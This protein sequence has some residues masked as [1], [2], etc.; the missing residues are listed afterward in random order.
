MFCR[1]TDGICGGPA[2]VHHVSCLEASFAFF[3]PS[4]LSGF[5]IIALRKPPVSASRNIKFKVIKRDFVT[6]GNA[7]RLFN[8]QE[9]PSLISSGILGASS[10]LR[11]LCLHLL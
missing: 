8:T 1:D 11:L 6:V 9:Q 5:V 4:F 10:V 7:V 3:H 2:A